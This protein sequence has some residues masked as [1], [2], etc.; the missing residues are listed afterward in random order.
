MRL[1]KL[2]AYAIVARFGVNLETFFQIHLGPDPG[3]FRKQFVVDVGSV[4][5][6]RTG[7]F[8]MDIY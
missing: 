4:Y 8:T 3:S 7:P 1:H 2:V 5:G 6:S